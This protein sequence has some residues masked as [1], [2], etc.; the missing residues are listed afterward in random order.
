VTATGTGE[1]ATD[2]L[3]VALGKPAIG[4]ASAPG[5]WLKI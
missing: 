4:N 1:T 5:A 3:P 2:R